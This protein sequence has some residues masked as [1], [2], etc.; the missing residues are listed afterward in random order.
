MEN[1]IF[2]KIINGEIPS[3]RIYEDDYTIGILDIMPS[4]PGQSLV[5]P[6][7]H[8][9]SSFTKA[10]LNELHNSLDGAYN[11]AKLIEEKLRASRTFL[12]VQGLGVDHLHFKLYPSFKG[13]DESI[14]TSGKPST[15]ESLEKVYK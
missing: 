5:I 1:C 13:D 7:L 2:C 6:K 4:K 15:K 14:D 9:P 3:Y 11:T 10:D 12:V 8:E